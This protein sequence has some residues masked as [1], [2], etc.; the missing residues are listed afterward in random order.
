M[1]AQSDDDD[2]EEQEDSQNGLG[3]I[4]VELRQQNQVDSD[5]NYDMR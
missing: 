4:S 3:N 5:N 2:E 1:Q